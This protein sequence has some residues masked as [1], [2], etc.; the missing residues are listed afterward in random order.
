MFKKIA[1]V[2]VPALALAIGFGAA[3][4]AADAPCEA[5]LNEVQAKWDK[6]YPMGMDNP[7]NPTYRSAT[8]S[9][10]IAKEKCKEGKTVETEQYLNVVRAHLNMPEHAAPHDRK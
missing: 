4:R 7:K 1:L 8:D 9:L 2:A 5:S 3:A 6:M 10:R